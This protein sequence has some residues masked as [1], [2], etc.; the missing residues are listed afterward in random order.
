[1]ESSAGAPWKN[2][3]GDLLRHLRSYG[4]AIA[5]V[6][7]GFAARYAL[8][9]AVGQ[10]LP[11][12]LFFYPTVILLAFFAGMGPGFLAT[13]SGG[14][15]RRFLDVPVGSASGKRNR[16]R[17]RGTGA[18]LYHGHTRKHLCPVIQSR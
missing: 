1:M 4:L 5:A 16:G 8:S 12:F 6:S 14:R 9:I 10:G 13:A 18:L 11:I 15:S 7:A 3:K 2:P 17:S